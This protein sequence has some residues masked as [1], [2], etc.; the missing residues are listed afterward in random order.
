MGFAPM[1]N[2]KIAICVFVENA[3]FGATFGVPIGKLMI[4]RYLQGPDAPGLQG[5]AEAMA[6]RNT[7]SATADKS[8]KSRGKAARGKRT[9]SKSGSAATRA[10][11]R[12]CMI[13]LKTLP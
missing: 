6:A 10:R 2:P 13:T 12:W 8:A 5:A 7:I 11:L 4:Q 1:N 9:G 3:G